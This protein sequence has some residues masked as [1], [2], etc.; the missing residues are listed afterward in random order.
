MLRMLA[1]RP[2]SLTDEAPAPRREPV[3]RAS[4][5]PAPGA[6]VAQTDAGARHR[7]EVREPGPATGT[8]AKADDISDWHGLVKRLRLKGMAAQLAE[9]SVVASWQNG[10][11]ELTV[12]P[13]CSSLVGSLA[14]QRLREGLAESLGTDIDL[15]LSVGVVETETPAQQGAREQLALQAATEADIAA[16]PLVQSVQQQFD[17]EIVA[18]SV[19]RID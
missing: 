7:D 19:R 11:L 10:V 13:S 2:A 17:A 16:D 4:P 12:E 5:V 8:D 15:R 6:G 9:N 1:F 14:E 18:D 3:R